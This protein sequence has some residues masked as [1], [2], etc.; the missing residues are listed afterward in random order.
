[1]DTMK[2]IML[3]CII[4]HNIIVED[5]QDTLNDNANVDYDHVDNDILNVEVSSSTL[6]G[7]VAYLQTRHIIHT[8]RIHQQLQ[9]ELVMDI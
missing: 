4:L 2:D 5:E 3:T 7:F 8:R 1:M 9:A 6:P